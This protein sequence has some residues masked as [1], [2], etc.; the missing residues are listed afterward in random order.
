MVPVVFVKVIL[1]LEAF[2][3]KSEEKSLSNL[4]INETPEVVAAIVP[5]MKAFRQHCHIYFAL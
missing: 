2:G 4:F 5:R 1:I 3:S